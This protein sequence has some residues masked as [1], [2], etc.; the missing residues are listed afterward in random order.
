L[1]AH[2]LVKNS[3]APIGFSWASNSNFGFLGIA[4]RAG[5]RY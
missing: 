1:V 4:L 3:L 2:D 5:V